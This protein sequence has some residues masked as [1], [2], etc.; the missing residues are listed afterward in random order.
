MYFFF[1]FDFT[2][3]KSESLSHVEI[4]K[5]INILEQPEDAEKADNATDE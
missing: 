3:S 5:T 1:F 2:L 4:L